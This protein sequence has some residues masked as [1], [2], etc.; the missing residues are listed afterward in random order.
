MRPLI[1]RILLRYP[2]MLR[3]VSELVRQPCPARVPRIELVLMRSDWEVE[4]LALQHPMNLVSTGLP[5]LVLAHLLGVI[6]VEKVAVKHCL[7]DSCDNRNRIKKT[8][9][10]IPIQPIRDVQRPINPECEKIM[11][12]YGLRAPSPLEHEKLRQNRHRFQPDAE[13]PKHLRQRPLVRKEDSQ[14]GGAREQV[15]DSEGVVVGIHGRFV[16]FEHQIYDVGLCRQE[17]DFEEC[18]VG[19]AGEEECPK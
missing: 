18:V 3:F 5:S 1:L 7:N 14:N 19:G 12:R 4:L 2:N 15:F 9:E 10:K 11:R 8:I 13:R 6:D 17:E 16:V